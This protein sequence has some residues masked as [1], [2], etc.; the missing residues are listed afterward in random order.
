M[1]N[2]PMTYEELIQFALENYSKGGDSVYE[3]W[4]EQAFNEYVQEFGP[5]TRK[6]A[7]EMFDLNAVI[8]NEMQATIW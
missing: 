8:W 7:L 6:K 4:D 1:M 5:M 2:E 3:C